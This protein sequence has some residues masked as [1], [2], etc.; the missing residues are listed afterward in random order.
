MSEKAEARL[1]IADRAFVTYDMEVEGPGSV[2]YGR[3]R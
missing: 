3:L 2:H 1:E